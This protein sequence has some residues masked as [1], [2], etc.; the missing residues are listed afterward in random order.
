[1]NKKSDLALREERRAKIAPLLTARVP[2]RHIAEQLEV[3][4][5]TVSRDVTALL[6][7]WAKEQRPDD[8]NRWRSVELMKLD[9]MEMGITKSAKQGH[10]GAIDRT[11][12]IMERRAKLLGLDEPEQIMIDDFVRVY[13]RDGGS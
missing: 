5:G 6:A 3:G 4:I 9:E 8:R 2:Y 7:Q 1:M 11:L 13:E 12:R 10:E